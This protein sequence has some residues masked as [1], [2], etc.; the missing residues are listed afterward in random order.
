[1]PTFEPSLLIESPDESPIAVVEVKGR[2]GMTCD[3][4]M[5]IRSNMLER[6][7]PLHIPYFLLLSQDRGFLWKDHQSG[8]FD[9]PPDY[10][11]PM[12]KVIAR[13]SEGEPEQRLY[14][15]VLE[16]LVL[17]WLTDLSLKPQEVE[18]PEKTLALAGFNASINDAMVLIG[19]KLSYI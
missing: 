4:A 5:E 16:L 10:E 3:V 8:N 17:E 19:Q 1:M 11:F 14:T 12:D 6:G 13:Y 18:E 2:R 9:T 15:S 7:L